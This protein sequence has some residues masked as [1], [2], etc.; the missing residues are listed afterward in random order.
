MYPISSWYDFQ[1]DTTYP[2]MSL[3][4]AE[5]KAIDGNTCE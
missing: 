1:K 4:E 2:T 5:E 3:E